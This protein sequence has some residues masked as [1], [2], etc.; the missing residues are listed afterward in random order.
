M[1]KETIIKNLIEGL[2]ASEK[3]IVGTKDQVVLTKLIK[4]GDIIVSEEVEFYD[5]EAKATTAANAWKAE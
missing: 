4:D 3:K 1:S 2:S 5:T